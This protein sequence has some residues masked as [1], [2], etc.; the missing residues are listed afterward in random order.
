V[1]RSRAIFL[2][3]CP[4]CCVQWDVADKGV[5]GV[6]SE[7]AGLRASRWALACADQR[8]VPGDGLVVGHGVRSQAG[9][10]RACTVMPGSV[11]PRVSLC[12]CYAL[13]VWSYRFS[14]MK[15]FGWVESSF[16][17]FDALFQPQSHPAR[18]AH[19]T[20]FVQGKCSIMAHPFLCVYK[21]KHSQSWLCVCGTGPCTTSRLPL[22]YKSRVAAVHE[23]GG[24][25]SLG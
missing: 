18:D 23:F 12:R 21:Q 22:A 11:S 15:R 17:N 9:C 25:G 1:P 16:W 6:E 8:K 14:E 24:C 5:Q 13:V 7:V 4:V 2:T 19:D 10:Q 20:F 3:V